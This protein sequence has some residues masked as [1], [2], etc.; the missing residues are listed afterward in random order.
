MSNAVRILP[1]YT[2]A[3]YEKWEGKWEVIEGIPYA[4]SPA[5]VPRHQIIS[6]NLSSE[7]R[8]QLKQCKK[9]QVLQPIDYVVAD[10]IILQPD[11]LIVCKHIEKKFLDFPPM[12]V[13]EILS[14]ATFLKDRHTK[15]SIYES[16]GVRYY[17]IVDSERNKAEVY[18][19]IEAKYQLMQ[20][21][22]DF[23]FSFV[24]DECRAEIFF[25]E[26]W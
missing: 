11:I 1:H 10:D 6:V 15:Y 19:L 9:C 22:N 25:K 24:L 26:I 4:M 13:V 8:M 21:G 5:P 7:F 18:E 17:L 16:Q 20:Q 23:S 3:D 2:Y 12:L 14:P